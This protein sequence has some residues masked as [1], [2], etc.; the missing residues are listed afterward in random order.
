MRGAVFAFLTAALAN[1]VAGNTF[2]QPLPSRSFYNTS[3]SLVAVPFGT[4]SNV[5]L[6]EPSLVQTTGNID[7]NDIASDEAWNKYK[8]KG[9]Y[10][11]C[12]LDMSNESAGKAMKD[13]RIPPSA[14][15]VW[16]GDLRNEIH[17]WGWH[18]AYY[19]PEVNCDFRDDPTMGTNRIGTALSALGL[20][21]LPASAGG[22]N[23]CYSIEH[24]DE[25]LMEDEDD[26]IPIDEQYYNINGLDYPCTG[27]YYRFALNK[28]GGAIFAQNLL[29]PDS[30]VLENL[31]EDVPTSLLP[32]LHRGS[33]ILW[34]YWVRDNPNLKNLFN[35]FVN[36]VRNDETLPLIARVLKNHGLER[37]PYWPGVELAMDSEDAEALLG[38]PIGSTIAHLL[39]QHKTA[40]GVK[41]FE[42]IHVFRD[43][44]PED[45]SAGAIPEVQLLF[46]ILD[47]PPDEVDD[48]DSDTEMEDASGV[49]RRRALKLKREDQ[50]EGGVVVAVQQM[51]K[52][53]FV[54]EHR[55]T[56]SLDAD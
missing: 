56:V 11:G 19:M 32:Q 38:S 40:L 1:S 42:A 6:S 20:S 13:L 18:K 9:L 10:Y 33:D 48:S 46:R 8:A 31:G 36:H 14:E 17:K 23:E 22:D 52:R 5:K 54:H 34:G 55:V 16:Q 50:D 30:A 25:T 7:L 24:F 27:A 15:S 35:Y 39:L 3:N 44:F 12:L 53:D 51:G 2:I 21:P 47:V 28:K 41:N 37:L 43:N 29:K 4:P 49:G 26:E 45:T